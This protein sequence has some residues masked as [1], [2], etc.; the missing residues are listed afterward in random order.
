MQPPLGP[1]EFPALVF[2]AAAL[3]AVYNDESWLQSDIPLRTV[4]LALRYG[5]TAFDTSPYYGVSEIVLG[6]ILNDPRIAL[7]FPR[8]SYKIVRHPR[9]DRCTSR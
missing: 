4:R 7:E 8:S 3:S 5:L 2:G 6:Q 9:A 1:L